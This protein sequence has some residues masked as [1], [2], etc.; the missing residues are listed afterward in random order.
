[1]VTYKISKYN[2]FFI[3]THK[4]VVTATQITFM[5]IFTRCGYGYS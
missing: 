1:M 3:E 2:L 5:F 4:I